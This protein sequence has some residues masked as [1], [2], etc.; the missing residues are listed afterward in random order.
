MEAPSRIK[1][2]LIAPLFDANVPG[3][4]WST[5]KW[6]EGLSRHCDVTVLT[7]HSS[8]WDIA[9]SPSE[10]LEVID[11]PDVTL[12]NRFARVNHEMNPGYIIFYHRVRRWI[13]ERLRDGWD[14][15]LVHQINPLALR[16]PSPVAGLNIRYVMGPLAG[17]LTT[18][19]GFAGEGTDKQW[20]RQLRHLDKFRLRYDP[21][22]K[23]TY[24]DAELILGV[25]PYVRALLEHCKIKR[26]EIM[27]ETGVDSVSKA[28]RVALVAG[29][30]LRL[31]FVGRVIRTKGVID[32]IRAVAIALR[33]YPLR[34]DII[35]DGDHKQACE[36]EATRLGICDHVHF[37]GWLPR[38]ELDSW[39]QSADIF[40]FPS[41]REPSGNVVYE[42]LKHGLPVITSNLGG[43]GYVVDDTCGIRV[44]PSNPAEY[45]ERLSCAIQELA[46][47]LER[48]M[49]MSDAASDRL[50]KL[51]LW[52]TKIQ[53][54]LRWYHLILD[55]N[56]K[57]SC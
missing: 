55:P 34:Y 27:S 19:R 45:A 25:A 49:K 42:S 4:S 30:P 32:A 13:K 57:F 31:L 41:F 53:Q 29:R 1:L 8:G 12:P 20:F 44:V 18:P 2:L 16:Y 48:L 35:G 3:E 28:K 47:D 51:A 43:P 5:Y 23:R 46:S 52:D 38:A 21:L 9:N 36:E 22:L 11:W 50:E 39:Y 6:V 7:T 37:H 17:S 33:K 26:F 14:F 56:K 15:D 40:L 10:A 24:R 54:M